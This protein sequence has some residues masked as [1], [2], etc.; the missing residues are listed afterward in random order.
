M[1]GIDIVF[2]K[3]CQRAMSVAKRMLYQSRWEGHR[4]YWECWKL[5]NGL[6]STRVPDLNERAY[7]RPTC[8]QSP[9]GWV[10][11]MELDSVVIPWITFR[12]A[13]LRH[14]GPSHRMSEASAPWWKN[15]CIGNRLGSCRCQTCSN[16]ESSRKARI[17]RSLH[18]WKECMPVSS[19]FILFAPR[20]SLQGWLGMAVAH[21]RDGHT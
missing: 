6:T 7:V 17:T 10:L 21:K 16:P 14:N 12:G 11:R 2:L 15:T 1:A 13:R 19:V 4:I 8:E 9:I 18:V 20:N 5:T 3:R